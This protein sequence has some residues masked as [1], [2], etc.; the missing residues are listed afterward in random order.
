MKEPLAPL[1][2]HQFILQKMEC[3][4]YATAIDLRKGYYHIPLDK[5]TQKLCTTV[6]PWGKYSYERL[7]MGIATSPDIFQ[8]AMNTIFGDLDSVFVYLDDILILSDDT[9]M[10]SNSVSSLV[11]YVY[12]LTPRCNHC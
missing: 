8:K 10:G 7:P 5:E 11:Q 9:I 2:F 4:K 3:F 6:L 12:H 1:T